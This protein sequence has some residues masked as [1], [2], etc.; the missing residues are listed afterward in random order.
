MKKIKK[1]DIVNSIKLFLLIFM[2]VNGFFTIYALIW[3]GIGLPQTNWALMLLYALS[4]LTEY[5]YF[6][7]LRR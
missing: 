7:W 1:E 2:M 6:M 4:A 3:F 5:G